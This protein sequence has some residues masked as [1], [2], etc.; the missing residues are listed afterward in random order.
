MYKMTRGLEKKRKE[1][2]KEKKERP[3][4]LIKEA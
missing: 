4:K 1:E 2:K 3:S